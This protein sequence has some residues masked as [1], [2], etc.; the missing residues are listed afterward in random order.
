MPNKWSPRLFKRLALPDN[1]AAA[2]GKSATGHYDLA[3]LA[4]AAVI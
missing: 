1:I 3:G 4:F 2:S